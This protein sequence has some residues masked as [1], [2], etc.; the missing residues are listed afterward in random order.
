MSRPALH[1][2]A[3]IALLTASTTVFAKTPDCTKPD[4]WPAGVAFTH[5]KNAGALDNS[6]LDFSK[7]KVTGLASEKIGKDLYRQVHLVQFV[8][9]SGED[10]L[11]MTVNEAS[12]QEC[13]MS[14]VDVYLV[15]KQLG[16]YSANQANKRDCL[17]K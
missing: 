16:D 8:K 10:V 1:C 12:S 3:S 15:S 9:R 7:T 17:N 14:N 6:G 5:L 4:A 13:S 2:L 11:A